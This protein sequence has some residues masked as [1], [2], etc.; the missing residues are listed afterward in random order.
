MI[1]QRPPSDFTPQMLDLFFPRPAFVE[2]L[3][4]LRTTPV[5]REHVGS[6]DRLVAAAA[7]KDVPLLHTAIHTFKYKRMRGMGK[8]LGDI[9]V[10]TA[11]EGS[12]ILCPVPLHWLRRFSRGFNQSEILASHVARARRWDLAHLLRRV[13]WTGS[14]VGRRRRERLPAMTGAFRYCG[15][16]PPP[17]VMLVDDLST[18]G[19]TLD[20]CARELK[21]AGVQRVE[22]LVIALG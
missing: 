3:S 18:T 4:A 15:G 13:R 1:D 2:E 21:R 14:Q 10:R 8:I 6:L 12:P 19:A 17:F 9:L 11:G 7:Y 5:I 20:A 16:V 22:G